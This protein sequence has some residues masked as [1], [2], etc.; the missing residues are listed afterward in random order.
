MKYKKIAITADNSITAKEAKKS[1]LKRYAWIDDSIRAENADL[2][3]VLGGDGF[4]L[5]T[6][7][8]LIKDDVEI[9]GMNCGTVGFLLNEY[10]E[11]RLEQ[12]IDELAVSILK[13]LSMEV[14]CVD[15]TT[16][17][18]Y[19]LNEVSLLRETAQ[20]A[21]IRVKVNDKVQIPEMVC[22]GV[23]VA[24]PAGSTA[25]N[26][27]AGGPI[28]PLRANVVALTPIS[29]FRPR[30]WKGALLP[31]DKKIEFEVLSAEKRPVSACA[32]FKEIR[33][34]KTVVVH[35]SQD[36]EIKLL[37]DHN[38][39]LQDRIIKEQFVL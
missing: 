19:A 37:F 38:L 12:R 39:S 20:A 24:T 18:N 5:H 16:S 26:L 9:F 1:L 15:G 30:R 14:T 6:M 11:D 21:K 3:I 2:V 4:M 28:I 22:D 29:V 25:Y 31:A 17:S 36:F 10:S 8:R 33:N 23:M 7:H 35:E 27:S 32:D 13:P 34:V